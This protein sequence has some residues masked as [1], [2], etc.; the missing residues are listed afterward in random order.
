MTGDDEEFEPEDLVRA[1]L[2][3]STHEEALGLLEQLG[4]HR[5]FSA[6]S[7]REL[8]WSFGRPSALD[9]KSSRA[10]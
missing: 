2:D 7:E 3:A 5:T 8:W 1:Y 9:L 10:Q 4:R 6:T